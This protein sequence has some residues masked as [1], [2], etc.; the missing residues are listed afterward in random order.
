MSK[1]VS[2]AP[3]CL[4]QTE[5][6]NITFNDYLNS[7]QVRAALHVPTYVQAYK[8]NGYQGLTYLP[9]F[10]GSGW[11]YEIFQ[12]YGYKMLHI[13]GDTDGLLSTHGL[14]KWIRSTGWKKTK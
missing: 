4:E 14:N 11:I 5:D 2:K 6:K 1:S 7:P 10:E 3:V 9:N 13:M 12:K 8:D